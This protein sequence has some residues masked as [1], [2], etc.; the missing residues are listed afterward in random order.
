MVQGTSPIYNLLPDMLSSLSSEADL[1]REH[2]QSI[3][4]HLLTFIAKEK[5]IDSLVEKLCLRFAATQVCHTQADIL[6][7][8]LGPAGPAPLAPRPPSP[9][10]LPP[11]GIV[12]QLV[13][14]K[15]CMPGP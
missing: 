8:I 10:K 1:P 6:C 12:L 15:A 11:R 14:C 4:R 2:F 7:T 5:Q 13:W 3:M 9:P